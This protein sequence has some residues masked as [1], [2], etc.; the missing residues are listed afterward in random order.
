MP[1]RVAVVAAE[2][3]APIVPLAAELR[4]ARLRFDLA[5]IR[6]YAQI[7]SAYVDLNVGRVSDATWRRLGKAS[8]T[9][10]HASAISIPHIQPVVQSPAQAVNAVLLVPFAEAAV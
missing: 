9:F 2:P 5:R 10:N 4:L 3:V 8:N 7:A 6:A 1:H